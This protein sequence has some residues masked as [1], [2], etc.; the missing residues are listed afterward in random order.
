MPETQPL[1]TRTCTRTCMVTKTL[2]I[3]EDAYELLK[4]HK[5]ESESFSQVIR[6]LATR[7]GDIMQFHGIWKDM[8]EEEIVRMKQVIADNRAEA[9]KRMMEMAKR[10][11]SR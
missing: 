8:P 5:G 6:K 1:Y 2:T 3:T 11:M 10:G 9:N 4:R 7:K